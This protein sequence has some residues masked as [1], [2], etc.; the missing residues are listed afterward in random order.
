M[1]GSIIVGLSAKSELRLRGLGGEA[2][3]GLFFNVL[4]RNS[5]KAASDLHDQKEQKPFSLSPLLEGYELREGYALA[6]CGGGITFRLSFLSEEILASAISAFFTAMTEGRI[7]HLSRKPVT[8]ERIDMYEGKF[9]S[10]SELLAEAQP[11]TV[12][13]LEFITPTSFKG[14]GIQTLFPEPR[15]VFSSLLRRWNAFSDIM[16]PEEYIEA[17][18]S[19]KV[20]NYSLRTE[21]VHF[22]R[23]KIIGF[24]GRIEYRLPQKSAEPFQKAVNALADFAFYAGTGAK[25]AMGMGQTRRTSPKIS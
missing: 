19:I 8:V 11:E 12:I 9:T 2:L 7:L 5:I 3:N 25:T 16:I 24:K 6:P 1:L 4:K 21:L 10:F 13:T 22:S 14:D 17:F 18:P 15:L 20:S 23:Y